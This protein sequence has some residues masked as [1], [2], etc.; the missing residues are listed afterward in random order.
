VTKAVRSFNATSLYSRNSKV[1]GHRPIASESLKEPTKETNKINKKPKWE[2]ELKLFDSI[3]CFPWFHWVLQSSA[4]GVSAQPVS[5]HSP[6]F[7]D[8]LHHCQ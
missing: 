1:T 2:F 7:K 8:A 6:T 3:V 5:L 4:F